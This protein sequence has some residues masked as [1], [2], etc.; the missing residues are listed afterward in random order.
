MPRLALR[1]GIAVAAC[2]MA[3]AALAGSATAAKSCTPTAAA[4]DESG[5]T[6]LINQRRAAAGVKVVRRHAAAWR[7][8]RRTSMAMARDGAFAHAPG[9]MAWAAGRPAGQNLARAASPAQAL[10]QMLASPSHR[11]ILLAAEWRHGGVG[12]ARSCS[13]VV[14]FTVNL[15]APPPRS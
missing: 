10:D 4:A 8:G 14:Y 1:A 2:G 11:A 12:A 15:M 9:G 3:M 5:L 7:A 13:G 6:V